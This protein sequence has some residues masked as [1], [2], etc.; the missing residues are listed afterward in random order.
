MLF[1]GAVHNYE[2]S[3]FNIHVNLWPNRLCFWFQGLI[4]KLIWHTATSATHSYSLVLSFVTAV[5][6]PSTLVML[7]IL[8]REQLLQVYV[9][10]D[11]HLQSQ[12]KVKDGLVFCS[13]QSTAISCLIVMLSC[14]IVYQLSSVAL[15]NTATKMMKIYSFLE[16]TILTLFQVYQT[17][18]LRFSQSLITATVVEFLCRLPYRKKNFYMVFNLAISLLGNS[19][20]LNCLM[21]I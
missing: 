3:S 4:G 1:P 15:H 9:C 8:M 12:R 14:I 5:D 17:L 11:C 19:L 10:K 18:F 7:V 16:K 6:V 21:E 13:Y 2:V 20:H